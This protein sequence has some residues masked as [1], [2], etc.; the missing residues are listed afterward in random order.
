MGES[1]R[2]DRDKKQDNWKFAIRLIVITVI[3]AG[4][5]LYQLGE[6]SFWLDELYTINGSSQLE[7]MH[8]SK[9]FGY[10]P[11]VIGLHL[12][13]I[14]PSNIP[15]ESATWQ[16]MGLNEF[17]VRLPTAIVGILTIPIIVIA[18]VRLLGMRG[19]IIIGLLLAMAPWH[20]YW[21]QAARF[22]I[23]QFLFYTLSIVFYFI[24][25]R[26]QSRP[27]FF[28]SMACM[29]LAFLSQPTALIVLGVF[30]ADWAVAW[31]RKRPL[32]IGAFEWCCGCA[33]VLLCLGIVSYDIWAAP[34]QWTHFVEEGSRHQ[35]PWRLLM[36]AQ[37]MIGPVV[38][39]FAMMT[40]IGTWRTDERRAV[41][42][43]ATAVIPILTFAAVSAWAFVGLR[44]A[45]I[46]LFGWLALTAI[47]TD[48]L[49]RALRP[50]Y[51]TILSWSPL[52]IIAASMMTSNYIYFNSSGNFH[53]RWRDAAEFVRAHRQPHEAVAASDTHTAAYYM[54]ESVSGLPASIDDV[55]KLTDPTWFIV[56]VTHACTRTGRYWL[57]PDAEL[58]E[59][60]PL[61]IIHGTSIM[62]VYK[63]TPQQASQ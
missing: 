59:V 34:S 14:D 53:A 25:T 63:F 38:G 6:G 54:Q 20:I 8:N 52:V 28:A 30:M 60:F 24:G 19:A 37:Y 11:T 18:S 39:V 55:G 15:A 17:V 12:A 13:G 58:V 10:V 62:Q 5:R 49:Q 50:R 31:A 51:G 43:L 26:H 36:G 3:A 1:W 2:I 22:Y 40:V 44:Y 48:V 45:F 7:Q 32:A 56:E 29:V 23:P 16:S 21:S 47:G 42:F 61:R 35:S 4:L 9:A 57:L 33:A 27:H 41:Y 46:A